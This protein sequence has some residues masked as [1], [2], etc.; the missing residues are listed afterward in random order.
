M[1]ILFFNT[2]FDPTYEYME[3]A[4]A[5]ILKRKG[6]EVS[7][8]AYTTY[9]NRF[10]TS[11]ANN[12]G[13]VKQ[14]Y[15]FNLVKIFN[16]SNWFNNLYLKIPLNLSKLIK[17]EQPDLIIFQTLEYYIPARIA[18]NTARKLGIPFYVIVNQHFVYKKHDKKSRLKRFIENLIEARFYKRILRFSDKVLAMNEYC[19][20]QALKY[21]PS[22]GHKLQQITLGIDL[23]GFRK[24]FDKYKEKEIRKLI[25]DN[26]KESIYCISTGKIN[27]Q[28]KTHLII[29]A[30]GKIGSP[31]VKLVLVGPIQ[32]GYYSTLK[33]VIDRYELQDQV[34]FIDKVD[35]EDLKYYFLNSDIAIWADLFTISTIEASACGIPVIVPNYKGYFHRIKNDNGLAIEPGNVEDLKEKLSYLVND[36]KIREE[37]GQRGKELVEEEMNWSKIVD[38]ILGD[39]Q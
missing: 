16:L 17:S 18:L 23:D 29:E 11:R 6:H 39:K 19:Y 31:K 12:I 5:R 15:S 4:I 1:K 8:L 2:N 21:N 32:E 3:N 25:R 20:E 27:S 14:S 33:K 10:G 24:F 22:V 13:R 36:R 28:K 7:V 26:D 37:M 34:I 35:S 9:M 38:K 30:I